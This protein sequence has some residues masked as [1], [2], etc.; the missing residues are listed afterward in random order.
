M[1]RLPLLSLGILLALSSFTRSEDKIRVYSFPAKNCDAPPQLV[2]LDVSRNECLNLASGSQSFRPFE[3]PDNAEWINDINNG[4]A[5]CN[6]VAHSTRGCMDK[7]ALGRLSLPRG[8]QQCLTYDANAPALS[9]HFDCVSVP[10]STPKTKTKTALLVSWSVDTDKKATPQEKT[11]TTT[12][13]IAISQEPVSETSTTISTIKIFQKPDITTSTKTNTI[14]IQP[15]VSTISTKTSTI[16]V[17]QEPS[18]K[19]STKTSILVIPQE[20]TTTISTKTSVVL[21]PQ[22]PATETSTRTNALLIPLKPVSTT[23]TRTNT[24]LASLQ[25][26]STTSTSTNTVLISLEPASTTSTRTNTFLISPK[27]A[28]RNAEAT[29]SQFGPSPENNHK[30]RWMFHPWSRS[31]ICYDCYTYKTD[32]F[33]KFDC[34]SGPKNPMNCGP[35]H[36]RINDFTSTLTREVTTTVVSPTYTFMKVATPIVEVAVPTVEVAVPI[37]EVATSTMDTDFSVFSVFVLSGPSS[38]SSAAAQVAEDDTDFGEGDIGMADGDIEKRSWHLRVRFM[39]PYLAGVPVCADAEWEKRGKPETEIRL[40]KITTDMKKCD[41]DSNTHDIDIPQDVVSIVT[42]TVTKPSVSVVE[43][44][45]T[46]ASLDDVDVF[47]NE[48]V[49]A[50]ISD[51]VPSHV[52]L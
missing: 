17:S 21:I 18:T 34:R 25:L 28:S 11:S 37:V 38:S 2:N 19:I 46:L 45:I 7:T 44:T 52:D 32:D 3:L 20:P 4:T 31:L 41:G 33:T 14:L 29:P 40:Q 15:V 24:V 12:K 42:K 1:T 48:Q 9:I 13:T 8:L 43:S 39:H 26:V 47:V 22:D 10:H 27:L 50:G 49:E 35:K 51:A 23:S 5:V 16:V 6:L 36:G 30:G